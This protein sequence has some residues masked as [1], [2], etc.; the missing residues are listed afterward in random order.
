MTGHHGQVTT[1]AFSPDGKWVASGS[2]DQTVKIWDA[3]TGALLRTLDLHEPVWRVVFSP[4]GSQLLTACSE[5][6]FKLW[7]TARWAL[8][9]VLEMEPRLSKKRKGEPVFSPDGRL[10]ACGFQGDKIGIWDGRSGWLLAAIAEPDAQWVN[11]FSPDGTRFLSF[12]Q[13][14]LA[15]VWDAQSFGA[16]LTLRSDE[17]VGSP[18][19]TAD[20]GR[21]LYATQDGTIHQWNTQSSHRAEALRFI[22][23]LEDRFPHSPLSLQFIDHHIR[24]EWSLD[25]RV[26][27]AALEEL[28]AYGEIDDVWGA[29]A[30]KTLLSPGAGMAVYQEVLAKA[31]RVAAVEPSDGDALNVLGAAQYRVGQFQEA[32]ATLEHCQDLRECGPEVNT[33]FLAMTHF[34][35][36]HT[37]QAIH[38][39]E[40]LR[41]MHPGTAEL[42]DLLREVES[43]VAGR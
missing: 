4:D 38:L 20:G 13:E 14:G 11:G 15:R 42:R 27:Q 19:F 21:I 24:D 3:A 7:S 33:A 22:L 29:A 2:L 16:L 10:I 40:K 28:E 1:A 32:V 6:T 18:I 26:R 31:R 5:R 35:L 37:Q 12:S 41:G 36:G 9:A 43:V 8:S 34:R 30:L 39:V 17:G 23:G 25:A